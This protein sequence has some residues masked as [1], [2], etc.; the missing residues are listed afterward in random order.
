[1]LLLKRPLARLARVA[2]TVA[3]LAA[4]CGSNGNYLPLTSDDPVAELA[5]GLTVSANPAAIP[6]NFK[7]QLTAIPAA[8]FTGGT[9]GDT[10]A[11]ALSALP[12]YLQLQGPLFEVKTQGTLP[13]IGRASCRERV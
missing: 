10:W 5:D 13:E 7:V 11:P 2:L 1:M 8:D 12:A 3:F 4:A 9:A 6:A